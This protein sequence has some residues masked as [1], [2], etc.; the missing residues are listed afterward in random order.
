MRAL[1]LATAAVVICG[2]TVV[3]G[4]AARAEAPDTDRTEP[5][6]DIGE[7]PGNVTYRL[8]SSI[9]A[10]LAAWRRTPGGTL[11]TTAASRATPPVGTKRMWPALDS[12]KGTIYTKEFTLRGVGHNIEVWVATGPAP[13]GTVGTDFPS[14]DCRGGVPGSTTVTDAQITA[15]MHEYDGTILPKESAAFSV[16]PARDGSQRSADSTVQG[17]DFS[18]DGTKV[19]T[20]VDNVRDAN[21]YHFPKNQTY[22]AGFFSPQ[23][24]DLTGRNVMTID[25]YDWAHRT[26]DNPPDQPD[27]D[28]C[29]SRPARPRLY[30]GIFAHEYQHLLEYYVDPN[31]HTWV[32]EG[33]SDYAIGLT[34]YASTT[35]TVFDR[36]FESHLICYDGFGTV[37]TRYNPNPQPCGGPE[38]SLTVWGDEGTG[39][40][41][42]ADYGIAWSFMIYLHDHFG[43]AILEFLHRDGRHQG[44]AGVQAAL[45]R[46]GH[47]AK[48]T[49]VLH[50]FEL[51]TLLDRLLKHG[52]VTGVAR[53]KVTSSGLNAAVNLANPAAYVKPGAAPN[54][55]DYVALRTAAGPLAGTGLTGL[56]FSGSRALDAEPL[57]WRAVPRTPLLSP[58]NP[59]GVPGQQPA[60]PISPPDLGP[61]PTDH[62]ALFSGN[63][64]D[65][66]VTMA[67]RTTVPLD[68]PVLSYTSSWSMENGFDW[69]YTVVSTDGGK[70]YETLANTNT[71]TASAPA[72]AGPGLTGSAP[73]PV[74]QSFDLTPYA[75]RSVILGFRYWSDPMVNSGGWY[76]DEVHVGHT[77]ISDGSSTGPFASPGQ[78]NPTP[79]E[80]W[81]VALVGIDAAHHR[82]L[83]RRVDGAFDFTLTA[84]VMHEFA[85]YP[86]LVAVVSCDDP[87]ETQ[88][89]YAPYTLR[90]NGVVQPG[91][92]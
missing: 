42:L 26:G 82:A 24:N 74:T 81:S 80:H 76:V 41:I 37:R 63:A 2:A 45:D 50:D 14:G 77:L 64:P 34:G 84:A 58:V 4:A 6:A 72:P 18:G 47:G 46:Y 44:V 33:L 23:F 69:G 32:N 51:S 15:L 92:R 54:G 68:D 89:T 67:F 71:R 83:V 27:A 5:A 30:E 29:K 31:E 90:V 75:G 53:D 21:F 60:P 38:N 35:H 10:T 48:F 25:A 52:T 49:E 57:L 12:E 65:S 88:Q 9:P 43:A 1:R 19:V 17:L 22:V 86:E 8:D 87:T 56:A 39:S 62:P 55:A 91:G 40:E 73:I 13:D 20:L 61:L 7:L 28:L 79:V 16:A 85:T 3:G 59:P 66:D 70:T 36:K 11:Q 78:L